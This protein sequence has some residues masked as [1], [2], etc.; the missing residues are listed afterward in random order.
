MSVVLVIRPRESY[1]N[2]TVPFWFAADVSRES[3]Q[4]VGN[5]CRRVCL[6]QMIVYFEA[7]DVA[8]D[9]AKLLFRSSSTS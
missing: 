7:V 5:S 9:H 1:A 8:G 3:G 2:V 4:E 6:S